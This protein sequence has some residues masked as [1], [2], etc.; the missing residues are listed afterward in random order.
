MEEEDSKNRAHM[1]KRTLTTYITYGPTVLHF[2][3]CIS[4]NTY[5]PYNGRRINI[6]NGI[7]S[8][9]YNA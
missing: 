4:L 1:G 7:N 5:L 3:P 6:I 8:D 2:I 9:A